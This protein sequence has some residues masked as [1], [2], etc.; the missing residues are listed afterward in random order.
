[1][2]V[3]WEWVK[4]KQA[5]RREQAEA[6]EDMMYGIAYD[7]GR[8][9]VMDMAERVQKDCAKS[10]DVLAMALESMNEDEIAEVIFR[11]CKE[12]DYLGYYIL[13]AEND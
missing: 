9:V 4:Q 11:L 2:V 8:G 7:Y 6:F 1:M 13:Y 5:E 10:R 3:D 12:I